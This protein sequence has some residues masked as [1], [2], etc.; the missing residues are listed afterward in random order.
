[1]EG[2]SNIRNRIR[3]VSS[4][5]K[6]TN[7]IKMVA[8]VKLSWASALHRCA[9]ECSSRLFEMLSMAVS[10]A[11]FYDLLN[12]G[13]W[14]E[15]NEGETLI[16]V[17]STA[18]GFC[19]SFNQTIVETAKQTISKNNAKYVEIFGKKGFCINQNV[20]QNINENIA[21][22]DM[23]SPLDTNGFAIMLSDL[24]FGYVTKHGVSNVVVVSS[25]KKNAMTQI[26]KCTCVL[27]LRVNKAV[28]SECV[29]IEDSAQDFINDVFKTY[30]VSLF[31]TLIVEHL[32]SEFSA[33]VI[34]MDNSVRNA[35]SMH[36]NL[37]ILYNNIR[38]AR[39]TQ[40]LTEIVSSMECVQ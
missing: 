28:N 36:D 32:V 8:T 31:K 22:H 37:N 5:V 11:R 19:G 24:V 16:I 40:E 15:R 7:A 35:N 26:A 38:Q 9:R 20:D 25:E 30:M 34:A 33:R 1:M 2:L 10:E 18:Q 13:F 23:N 6:A 17:L 14:T 29:M 12:A 39:I 4:I 27:P 3:A 21:R